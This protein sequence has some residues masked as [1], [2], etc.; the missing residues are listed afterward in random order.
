MSLLLENM[1]NVIFI[2]LIC[3]MY[4]W[5]DGVDVSPLAVRNC[6]LLCIIVHLYADV[7]VQSPHGD[8]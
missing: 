3:V 7:T 6:A 1:H 4:S 2:N 8:K 5:G